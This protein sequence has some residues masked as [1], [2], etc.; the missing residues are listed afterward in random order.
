MFNVYFGLFNVFTP[1]IVRI[2][3]QSEL[4]LGLSRRVVERS[5]ALRFGSF[6]NPEQQHTMRCFAYGWVY[7][8]G[9][10]PHQEFCL[11][12]SYK[13][14]FWRRLGALLHGE[15]AR[16]GGLFTNLCRPPTP[17]NYPRSAR[18]SLRCRWSAVVVP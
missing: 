1:F 14:R 5:F 11:S 18:V 13:N 12:R 16:L 7:N 17:A 4:I 3:H 8:L 9:S 2:V 15:K 10:G 6:N